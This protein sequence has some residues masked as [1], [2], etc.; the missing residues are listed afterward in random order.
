MKQKL[1]RAPS[2]LRN[3]LS[4]RWHVA[5]GV[6]A[7]LC[8]VALVAM[9]APQ[10]AH[11]DDETSASTPVR[12]ADPSTAENYYDMLGTTESG[13]RYAGRIWSD[14]T[15]TAGNSITLDSRNR[16]DPSAK[17]TVTMD[18]ADDDGY[19]FLTTYSLMGSSRVVNGQ[20]NSPIDLVMML[21]VST[22]MDGQDAAGTYL[23]NQGP[24]V[25][26]VSAA[27]GLIDQLMTLNPNNRVAVVAY[28]GGT[29]TVLP[30][31]HYTPKTAGTYLKLN[32]VL[33]NT[34]YW[35][36]IA[37]NVQGRTDQGNPYFYADS[38]Y[39]QGALAQGMGILANNK[40]T[41]YTSAAG[42]TSARVPAIMVLS[43]GGTNQLTAQPTTAAQTNNWWNPILGELPVQT[44]KPG[45]AGNYQN[46]CPQANGNPIYF[47]IGA[48][49]GTAATNQATFIPSRVAGTLM[50]AGYM[51][52][53]I[54]KNY[55]DPQTG[56]AVGL[57]GYGVGLN[58]SGLS[59]NEKAELQATLNPS[60]YF[61]GSSTGQVKTAYN[62][63]QQYVAG[64]TPNLPYDSGS[65][66]YLGARVRGNW[67]LT[68]LPQ[69]NQYG[70]AD[71]KSPSELN[72][73]DKYYD[74]DNDSLDGIFDQIV[75]DVANSAFHPVGSTAAAG[76]AASV[77]YRDHL[78][79]YMDLRNVNKVIL[80]GKSY[81]VTK[82]GDDTWAIANP[83]TI[84]NPDYVRD[85]PV[86][87]SQ[88]SMK[89]VQDGDH[90]DFEVT[91]PEAMV[92]LRVET[93][94]LSKDIDP[95]TGTQAV[96]GRSSNS[97]TASPM[98]VVYTV[99]LDKDSVLNEDGTV[100]LSKIDPEYRAAH[101]NADGKLEFY[102]NA[103]TIDGA[104]KD[105]QYGDAAT[106]FTPSVDNRFYRFQDTYKIYGSTTADVANHQTFT[107]EAD[108]EA[109]MGDPVTSLANVN[110]GQ[111]YYLLESYYR[112]KLTN[113]QRVPVMNGGT[114]A[115]NA[116]GD[117]LW[118][119]EE[120][121]AVVP[122]TGAELKGIV[123][124]SD[125]STV[126]IPGSLKE[127][128]GAVTTAVGTPRLGQ[129]ND[130]EVTKAENTTATAPLAMGSAYM[131]QATG[132]G[133]NLGIITHLGNNGVLAVDAKAVPAEV[134]L[135]GTK[136]LT[137]KTLAADQFSFTITP[138]DT[139]PESDP[140]EA[141]TVTNGADGSITFIDKASYTEPG[142]YTYTVE[143]T[144]PDQTAPGISYDPTIYT[145][146]VT[147]ED[148]DG[149]L[150]A[151]TAI[152]A[153]GNNEDA[154][155]FEN[156]Y[157]PQAV[158]T[159]IPGVKHL[160]GGL[161]N[162]GEFTFKLE[163]VSAEALPENPVTP[164]TPE[165]TPEENPQATAPA[166]AADTD[167]APENKAVTPDGDQAT[168]EAA[169][170]KVDETTA[171]TDDQTATATDDQAT[172]QAAPESQDGEKATAD[173]AATEA[174]AKDEAEAAD[175]TTTGDKAADA[176]DDAA[177]A[178]TPAVEA[179][180]GPL[181][182]PMPAADTTTNAPNGEFNF[183]AITFTRPGV[184]TYKVSEVDDGVDGVTYDKTVYTVKVTV[185]DT[186]AVLSAD[187]T[188]E[189]APEVAFNN[190]FDPPQ[191]S[192]HKD[193]MLT[194]GEFTDQEL[195]ADGEDVVTYRLSI[196]NAGTT[197]AHDVVV[198]D[199]IPAG[200]TYVDGSAS[201]GGTMEDGMLR[202]ELGTVAGGETRQV[203]FQCTVPAVTEETTWTNVASM[204]FSNNPE[205][206]NT[207]TPSNE[208]VIKADRP[209]SELPSNKP[210]PPTDNP[211]PT[212]GNPGN[213]A[214]PS[215]PE[216]P[217]G[218]ATA[219]QGTVV[220]VNQGGTFP[221]TGDVLDPLMPGVIGIVA[222]VAV[223][224]AMGLRKRS[225]G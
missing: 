225:Q 137:G 194:G 197:P 112:N 117:P 212:P 130:F 96:L 173:D 122:R 50:T 79:R 210:K 39:L 208:V 105:P 3:R 25:N 146:V 77:T 202:W 195:T 189:G 164:D 167:S 72:Y 201:D 5:L 55:V 121:F 138:A 2:R 11:A 65:S 78:G 110:D 150:E 145:V 170:A 66:T 106:M 118:E 86:D 190:H 74:A 44:G 1:R 129:L 183:G 131:G 151:T 143:E 92:P 16:Q 147:V 97:E 155:T 205:G 211:T 51:E 166:E 177:D 63:V 141:A 56:K 102:S 207:P 84:T 179:A 26:L 91:V 85:T 157:N 40:D 152:T 113:G 123:N 58:T 98:R 49:N 90:Y 46:F 133:S 221:A 185:T 223:V 57:L 27:N 82:T 29:Y 15:V 181:T 95:A 159:T 22:S 180:D 42:V 81:D 70:V 14:K 103:Y 156:S 135:T 52:K 71:I 144:V 193:Q 13:G 174:G 20:M 161:L 93:V 24:I 68:H 148:H 182:V 213:P 61:N 41:T 31:G 149:T 47:G 128:D 214:N 107:S 100:N 75:S 18:S 53:A 142:T 186:D 216:T 99:G 48:S 37:S 54:D 178:D 206:P 172:D 114:Q 163:P 30:L 104:Q 187:V 108:A 59:A 33:G 127:A 188:V 224:V 139:N 192:I 64:G 17:T 209:E 134:S 165:D 101:T 132:D 88:L 140:V 204:T 218:T 34:K 220:P 9:G 8:C 19:S 200:L 80:W 12:T 115:T 35:N 73:I 87:L 23:P 7:V 176:A 222:A 69:N 6:F 191:L 36:S 168:S 43:D 111:T 120:V 124:G 175:D 62:A 60:A 125:G 219:P 199:A 154:V 196:T 28:S 4:A 32:Q 215:N 126:T 198:T 160:D 158:T 116:K 83:T 169:I 162:G 119:G 203:T 38:T 10:Q 171:A 136:T 45:A 184:Y 67:Y 109:A 217:A 153:N 89:A 21:D 76:T 94:N